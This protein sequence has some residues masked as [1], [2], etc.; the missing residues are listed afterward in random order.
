MSPDPAR[1]VTIPPTVKLEVTQATVTPVTFDIAIVPVAD[2]GTTVQI[3]DG[4]DGCTKTVTAYMSPLGTGVGNVNPPL[5]FTGRLSSPLSCNTRPLPARPLTVPPT[6][7][8]LVRQLTT[9]VVTFALVMVPI[10]LVT[11]HVCTGDDGCTDTVTS[12]IW[13]L[14]TEV[15][16]VATPF[17]DTARSS[18][19]LS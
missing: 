17:A 6:V 12:Y 14:V 19:P 9:T 16:N 8:A 13:P 18:P 15:A 2:A 7:K 10:P 3:C 1:P 5:A 11:V 4:D